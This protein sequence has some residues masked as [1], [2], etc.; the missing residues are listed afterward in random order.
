MLAARRRRPDRNR[1][2]LARL[3]SYLTSNH[4]IGDMNA[5]MT[6]VLIIGVIFIGLNLLSDIRI[7]S[8]TRGHADSAAVETRTLPAWLNAS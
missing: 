2:C 1:F 7:A 4:I 3:R 5:V 8:L 6:C